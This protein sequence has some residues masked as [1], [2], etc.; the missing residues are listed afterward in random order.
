MKPR[1][2]VT[3]CLSLAWAAA[4]CDP[5]TAGPPTEPSDPTKTGYEMPGG[6]EGSAPGVSGSIDQLCGY[7]CMRFAS[8]CPSASDPTC[9]S[10]CSASTMGA[11]MCE[12]FFRS[13]LACL[14]TSPL[15]CNNGSIDPNV[16]QTE[17]IDFENCSHGV[18]TG[19]AGAS[20]GSSAGA[21]GGGSKI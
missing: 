17:N 9:A 20:G 16:C 14:S 1:L 15:T 7:V 18:S 13:L 19:T 6:D 10:N 5:G 11:P 4:A 8:V 2:I 12:S 21:T 3:L